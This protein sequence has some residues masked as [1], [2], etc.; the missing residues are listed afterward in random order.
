[1]D[2]HATA[3]GA[4]LARI[5]A[6]L[7][8]LHG[9]LEGAGDRPRQ[10]RITRWLFL[11]GLGLAALCAFLSLYVQVDGLIGEQ[12]IAPAGQ[13]MAQADAYADAMELAHDQGNPEGWSAM[14][15]YL[16]IPTLL[17]LGASDTAIHIW[18][19]IGILLCVLLILDIAPGPAILG[20]WLIYLSLVTA[21]DTFLMYQWDSLL[22]ETLFAAMFIAPW[23]RF[24]P[25]LRGDRE[26][27]RAGLWLVR[28]VLFKLMFLS[29]VVKL[30]A[31]DDSWNSLKALDVH[32]FTQPIP[33][34]FSY[35]AHHLPHWFHAT[36]IVLMLLIELVLP[37]FMFAPR[38]MRL[39]AAGG[40]IALM[41]LIA[42]T[43]NYGFF[44]LLTVV[45]ALSL[46]DDATLRRLTPGKLYARLPD[47]PPARMHVIARRVILALTIPIVIVSGLRMWSRLDRDRGRD[48]SAF[49]QRLLD[50]TMPF[51][52]VNAYGLFASMT[53]MRPEI[54]VEGS[55]DGRTWEAYEFSYKPGPM[56]RRPA[57]AGLHMPRLDW[58]MW[59]AALG[60]CQRAQWFHAFMLRL[61]QGS[62]A[63]RDLL[64]RDPFG[65][66]P[67]TYIR[68][69]L[70]LYTFT[71][72]GSPD[73]WKRQPMGAYCPPVMLQQ[74]QL[75]PAR[76]PRSGPGP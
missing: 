33:N 9:W 45:L 54:I 42:L 12:G 49:G 10:Y 48:R 8:R 74:G 46:L 72:M 4:S 61:L 34:L 53:T 69:T 65:D 26:P 64:H 1:V 71:D 70:Y 27:S 68:S 16:S 40:F 43:G 35:Y 58:Q 22:L 66:Q 2:H 55:R 50:R 20:L 28:L 31:N 63:V 14:E 62:P 15:R 17:W 75:A 5:S 51:H 6:L 11:R 37:F 57:F 3:L 59:F 25:A 19:L 60:G 29:G 73:W 7:A 30:L 18:M 52:T 67:P 56:D 39:V 21:G 24:W 41:V 32:Y 38:R 36:S 44:N 47:T 23:G 76:L 13:Y